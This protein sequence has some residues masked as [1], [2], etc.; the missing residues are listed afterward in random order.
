MLGER[1]CRTLVPAF[2]RLR[3]SFLRRAFSVAPV[4]FLVCTTFHF[5]AAATSASRSDS[6]RCSKWLVLLI[7]TGATLR[8]HFLCAVV[9]ARR[10]LHLGAARRTKES[11]AHNLTSSERSMEDQTEI[12][13]TT[14]DEAETQKVGLSADSEVLQGALRASF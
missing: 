12:F 9:A 13:G 11:A 8:R 7:K 10:C 6:G 5:A 14:L 4:S 2:H 1:V 3:R